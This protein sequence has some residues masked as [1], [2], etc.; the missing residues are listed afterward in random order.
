MTDDTITVNERKFNGTATVEV[1]G[2]DNTEEA[3][4]YAR[5]FWKE[6]YDSRPSKV[7]AEKHPHRFDEGYYI[8]MVSDHSSGSLR[9]SREYEKQ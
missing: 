7:V 8:A 6:E 1:E 9:S 2:V 4:A 3:R 5:K